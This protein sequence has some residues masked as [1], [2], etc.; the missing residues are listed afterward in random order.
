MMSVRRHRRGVRSAARHQRR[1][2]R[3]HRG[4]GCIIGVDTVATKRPLAEK[5]GMTD[6]VDASSVDDPVK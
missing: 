1:P 5:F 6:F 3:P 4:A 2:R